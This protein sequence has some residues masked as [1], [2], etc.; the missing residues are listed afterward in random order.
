MHRW[1]VAE[2]RVDKEAAPQLAHVPLQRRWFDYVE[3]PEDEVAGA[4]FRAYHDSLAPV[5]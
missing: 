2:I 4:P 5:E 1:D 3:Q